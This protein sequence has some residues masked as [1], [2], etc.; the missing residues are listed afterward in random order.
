MKLYKIACFYYNLVKKA[1]VRSQLAARTMYE[2]GEPNFRNLAY[3]VGGA[4]KMIRYGASALYMRTLGSYM[5]HGGPNTPWSGTVPTIMFEKITKD[6]INKYLNI[7]NEIKRSAQ[8]ET[9]AACWRKIADN[10]LELAE[11]YAR[12]L[13]LDD[14]E[15]QKEAANNIKIRMSIIDQLAHNH[16]ELFEW[17]AGLETIDHRMSPYIADRTRRDSFVEIDPEEFK[18]SLEESKKMEEMRNISDLEDKDEIFKGIYPFLEMELPFKDTIQQFRQ[19]NK[20]IS[21]ISEKSKL[22]MKSYKLAK[23]FKY[24]IK[25]HSNRVDFSIIQSSYNMTIKKAHTFSDLPEEKRTVELADSL[26]QIINN[27]VNENELFKTKYSTFFPFTPIEFNSIMDRLTLS[28]INYDLYMK[29]FN[30]HKIMIRKLKKTAEKIKKY[31]TLKIDEFTKD[32][33]NLMNYVNML[34]VICKNASS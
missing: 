16:G 17:F 1:T 31:K 20:Y 6:N 26:S 13:H 7:L 27:F 15:E 8:L 34:S 29:N 4:E 14:L 33:D 12:Y 22:H 32:I 9:Q 10:I 3:I 25:I 11:N 21:E 30:E 19:K 23:E 18:E 5:R 2:I 24:F 28:H